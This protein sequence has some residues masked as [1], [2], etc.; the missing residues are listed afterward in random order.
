MIIP[1]GRAYM[2][3]LTAANTKA[4]GAMAFLTGTV[5]IYVLQGKNTKIRG[6]AAVPQG[7]SHN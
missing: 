2:F 6:R 4:N 3:G 1:M 7:I 5:A